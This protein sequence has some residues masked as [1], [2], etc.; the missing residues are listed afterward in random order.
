MERTILSRRHRVAVHDN[1]DWQCGYGISRSGIRYDELY[2]VGAR[3]EVA[4]HVEGAPH[5]SCAHGFKAPFIA[6]VDDVGHERCRGGHVVSAAVAFLVRDD[7]VH[8]RG[9]AIGCFHSLGAV[10]RPVSQ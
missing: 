5:R 1:V 10:L 4:R 8:K 9:G 6:V 7:I 3:C 2:I